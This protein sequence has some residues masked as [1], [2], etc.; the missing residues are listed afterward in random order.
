M[1]VL[2]TNDDGIESVGLH[3]LVRALVADGR[4]VVVVAPDSDRS[5]SG[6]AIGHIN[7]Q[8]PI[9]S[10]RVE[11]P[12]LPGVPAYSIDGPPGL[13]VLA[14]RLGGFGTPPDLIVSGINPGC[15]TGRAVLHSGTV[16]A[17]LTGANFGLSGLAVSIDV[18][19][20]SLH[21][22]AGG[23]VTPVAEG[24]EAYVELVEAPEPAS[25]GEDAGTTRDAGSP[26]HWDTAAAVAAASVDWL[27]AAPAG[28]VLNINVPDV[29][30][31]AL[32]GA[33]PATL[34]PFGTVRSTVVESAEDGG[35]LQLQLRPTAGTLPRDCD[36]ALVAGGFVAV[37]ALSGVSVATDVDVRDVV[38][39]VAE[40][41]SAA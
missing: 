19:S 10:T 37:T 25:S 6:A 17:A 33:R 5:G 29:P 15:N 31:T 38:D 12:G 24:D 39:V 35:A 32:A 14:A 1:K 7:I 8:E 23:R 26:L 40:V 27:V 16:G 4:D 41:E 30:T 9:E 11:L 21:E 2:V 13:C 3:A 22:Q 20:T 28:T 36:T 18:T 34:A